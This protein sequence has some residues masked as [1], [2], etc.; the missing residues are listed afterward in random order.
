MPSSRRSRR[1]PYTE[2]H[3]PVD[4]T[5]LTGGRRTEVRRGEEW[6]VQPVR[7]SDKTYRCPGCH[8]DIGP[9]TEHLVAWATDSLF[10]P[11]AA[12]AARRHWHTRCW[13]MG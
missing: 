4:L 8:Q 5:R 7:P 11:D 9:G 13:S 6:T 12:L 1:R 3:R 10:G 2:D